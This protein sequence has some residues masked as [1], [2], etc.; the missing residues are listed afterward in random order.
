M[1]LTIIMI[2]TSILFA[3]DEKKSELKNVQVLSYTKKTEIMKYMKKTVAKELGVK[4]IF[5]HNIRDYSSDEKEKKVA[6][7]EMMRMVMHINKN[8][9][10]PMEL[11]EVSCWVCHRGLKH[12][13]H[14]HK[15]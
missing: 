2:L 12:P 3:E 10:Q 9:M 15:K 5:C 13:D 6:A 11:H 8:T 7:R 14:K 4:C 1:R